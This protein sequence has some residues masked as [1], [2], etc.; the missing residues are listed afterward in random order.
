MA[1]S[2]TSPTIDAR[3][4]LPINSAL[5]E[6]SNSRPTLNGLVF[7][8]SGGFELLG[9]AGFDRFLRAA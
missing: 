2:R 8:G 7:T 5:R 3:I 1:A 6:E 4:A 9:R